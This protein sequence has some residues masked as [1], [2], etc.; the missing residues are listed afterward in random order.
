MTDKKKTTAERGKFKKII[1]AA[2]YKNT[3]LRDLLLGDTSGKSAK[4]IRDEFKAHV[5]SHLFIEDT[6]KDEASY[7]FYDVRIPNIHTHVKNC[8]IIMYAICHRNILEDYEKEGYYGDRS[9][10]MAQMI[11]DSLINNWDTANEF[12]IGAL[13]MIDVDIYNSTRFYGSVL[14]FEIPNFRV[15]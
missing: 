2:L 4:V 13:N 15:G 1:H 6:L 9:D 14:T 10:I 11:E 3:D 12:G 5:K 8:I 7:V